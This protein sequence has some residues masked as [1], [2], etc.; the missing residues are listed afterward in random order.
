MI[1]LSLVVVDLQIE[2]KLAGVV[3]VVVEAPDLV[4]NVKEE[5]EAHALGHL[6]ETGLYIYPHR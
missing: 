6:P 2:N 4:P 5:V 1:L 3:E